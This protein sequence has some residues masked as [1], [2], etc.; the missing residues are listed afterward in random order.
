MIQF[1]GIGQ[2]PKRRRQQKFAVIA[3]DASALCELK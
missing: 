3:K 2:R 1:L